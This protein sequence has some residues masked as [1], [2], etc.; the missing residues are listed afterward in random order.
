VIRRTD[1]HPGA[2]SQIERRI[3]FDDGVK[4]AMHMDTDGDGRFD[5]TDTYDGFEREVGRSAYAGKAQRP[6]P[7]SR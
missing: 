6:M 1:W 3:R 5:T 7:A 2:S 4:A